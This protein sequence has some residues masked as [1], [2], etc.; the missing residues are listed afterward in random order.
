MV[1]LLLMLVLRYHHAYLYEVLM[2]TA[3]VLVD[4]DPVAVVASY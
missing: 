1:A 4:D 2:V 3:S